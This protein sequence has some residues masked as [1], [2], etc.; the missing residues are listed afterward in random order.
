MIRKLA[1]VGAI[2]TGAVALVAGPACAHVEIEREGRVSSAGVVAATL[3]VPNEKD[4]AGTVT[5]E[6]VFPA[7]PKLTTVEAEAV[8][9]WTATVTEASDGAV[10]SVTWTGGPITGKEAAELPIRVGDVPAGVDAVDFEAVQT[11]DDGDVVRWVDETHAGGE[12][13]ERPAPVLLVRGEVSGHDD[14]GGDEDDGVSTGA[15]IASVLAVIIVLVAIALVIRRS[16]Q[17]TG[18]PQA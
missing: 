13:P 7:S 16:R 2:V 14:S 10:E 17:K 11:Y 12:E 1:V 3:V 9:G 18:T 8:D 6:L 15:I 4:D 5:I